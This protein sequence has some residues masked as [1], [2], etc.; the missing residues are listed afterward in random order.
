MSSHQRI[1]G[2]E[3]KRRRDGWLRVTVRLM[4]GS[5]QPPRSQVNYAF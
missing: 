1:K 3:R 5:L 4:E 2:S